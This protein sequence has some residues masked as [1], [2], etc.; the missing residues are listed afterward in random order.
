MERGSE[1][2]FVLP[3]EALGAYCILAVILSLPTTR[4]QNFCC[5]SSCICLTSIVTCIRCII[6]TVIGDQNGTATCSPSSSPPRS[7][8]E[9][10]TRRGLRGNLLPIHFQTTVSLLHQTTD[11]LILQHIRHLYALHYSSHL[12]TSAL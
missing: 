4:C 6:T 5:L 1:D 8:R 9:L 10:P 7:P 12:T 3:I 2:R 11:L